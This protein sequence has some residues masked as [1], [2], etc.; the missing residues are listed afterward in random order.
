MFA[1]SQSAIMGRERTMARKDKERR[2]SRDYVALKAARETAAKNTRA[3]L[4]RIARVLKRSER[5]NEEQAASSST[6]RP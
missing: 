2:S 1:N 6:A 4:Q 3:T 5:R